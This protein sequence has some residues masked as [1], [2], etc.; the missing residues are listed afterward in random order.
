MTTQDCI[1]LSYDEYGNIN[2]ISVQQAKSSDSSKYI[3]KPK[4]SKHCKL[5]KLKTTQTLVVCK[6]ED[7]GWYPESLINL[8]TNATICD[9]SVPVCSLNDLSEAIDYETE[10]N[11]CDGDVEQPICRSLR[12]V[13]GNCLDHKQI[14]DGKKD[15]HD[16]Y[17]ESE[18]I[19]RMHK[20]ECSKSEFKCR[21]GKCVSKTK[22]CDHSNDCGDLTDE[23]PVCSC[24]TYLQ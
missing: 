19:C 5:R 8:N 22:F 6:N 21:N 16:G 2:P 24:F 20:Q 4:D 13:L 18:N 15:C 12:C 1:S 11:Q 23:P 9:E 17:D 7:Q 14:C 3:F 10:A